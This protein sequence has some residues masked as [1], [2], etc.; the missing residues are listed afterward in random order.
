MKTLLTV[1][2]AF[3]SLTVAAQFPKDCPGTEL[4]KQYGDKRVKA[5]L[6]AKA[7]GQ[8]PAHMQKPGSNAISEKDLQKEIVHFNPVTKKCDLEKMITTPFGKWVKEQID[9]RKL[10]KLSP[11]YPFHPVEIDA[12]YDIQYWLTLPLTSK[13]D[14]F[15]RRAVVGYNALVEK[16]KECENEKKSNE[17][18][19]YSEEFLK[20]YESNLQRELTKP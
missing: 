8:L 4:I 2:L 10:Q 5:A 16:A 11:D 18:V 9:Y 6:A 19:N 20:Y 12:A 3:F 15:N 14:L 1:S 13:A 17:L 7:S